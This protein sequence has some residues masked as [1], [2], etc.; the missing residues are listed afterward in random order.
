MPKFVN[1]FQYASLLN[2]QSF[3]NYW[4]N[5]SRD[6]DIVTWSDFE[7]KRDNNWIKEATLYFSPEDLKFYQNA[8]TPTLDNGQ[9]NPYYDPYFHPDQNWTD[10]IFKKFAPQ[11]QVNANI[12]GGTDALKYFVSLGY[13][14]Q[15]GL[16]KTDYMPFSDEMNFKKDRYNL[17]SNFD[18]DVNKNFRISID[19]GTQFVT[20]TGMDN[21]GYTWEK[22]ILWSS[23]IGSPGIVD[24]KFILPFTNQN[25]TLNPLLAIAN[26]NNYTIVNNSILNSSVRLSHKLDF[27]TKGLSTNAR[28]AYDSYFS[29]RSGGS[30]KPLVYGARRNPNG[31]NLNPILVRLNE[32]TPPQRWSDWYNGK[33][34]KL[35]GEVSLN[36]NRDFGKHAVS[37]LVLYNMEKKYDPNLAYDL[38]HAYLGLVGRLTYNYA[39][40]YF[41]EYNMGYNGSENFPEGKRFGFL[42]AYSAGWIASNESF[43]PK[44][45]YITY[46]KVRGSLGKVG[47]DNVGGARY[48]YLPDTWTYS[49]GYTFGGINNK[50]FV[51][52][53]NE[54][55][56]GNPNVTWETATKSNIGVEIH[57]IKDKLSIVYD[58]FMERRKDILSYKGTVPGIV[59]ATLPP[60]NLG[61]VKNWG[62]ELELSYR[63]NHNKFNYWI[64]GNVSNTKNIIVFR[65]EAIIPGLEYQASTGRPINQPLYLQ[66]NGLYTSWSDLY[67]TDPNGNP[68]LNSP[69]LALNKDGLSYKNIA[70]GVVYQKDLGFSGVPLQPGEIRLVDVNEDGVINEKDYTR[71]GKTDIPEITYGLSFG[72][73]FKGFDFSAL[74]QGVSG[75]SKFAMSELHFNKQQ[76]L[77]E[78]DEN[79]FTLERY[80]NGD[81]ID[82]PIAAYNQAANGNTF[83]QKNTAYMRLKN[84]EIGYTFKQNLLKKVGI[85]SARLYVNG[86]NLYTWSPNKI[87]GDPENLGFIGYP[88]TRTYNMGLNI[89]F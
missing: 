44:N 5:H 19:V 56:I 1:S 46:L 49:G 17:R 33:W 4:I 45:D 24:G 88:L 35:Y 32:E 28:V 58:H 84:L 9:K 75:V 22:R 48:L 66:A 39:G 80:N 81:R 21:D 83:F 77:F 27:L 60:Y 87:W 30:F 68:I 47:N 34:R 26:S 25:E 18:F 2:E 74:L 7:K 67:K 42:P 12:N 16:F 72:F 50:N 86:N 57:L 20:T 31:D 73:D 70:G 76:S 15:G 37:G 10:Q 59:Q 69:V 38:P 85:Q 3:E 63:N 51:P 52:G 55:V 78:V 29:S 64:K 62:N 11:T 82:F 65:D 8:H 54:N 41:A 71:T 53:A 13:L 43:F 61:E 79:R 40:R 89:N 36:Y 23:P 14:T 6:A